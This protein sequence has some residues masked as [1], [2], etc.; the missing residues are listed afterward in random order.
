MY[1]E[2]SRINELKP[3]PMQMLSTPTLKYYDHFMMK[4]VP[5]F[6]FEQNEGSKEVLSLKK[7]VNSQIRNLTKINLLNFGMSIAEKSVFLVKV[8]NDYISSINLIQ[9][10]LA[11]MKAQ[12]RSSK[13]TDEDFRKNY[14]ISYKAAIRELED[15]IIELDP[16]KQ[17]TQTFIDAVLVVTHSFA[18]AKQVSKLSFDFVRP[19]SFVFYPIRKLVQYSQ[20]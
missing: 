10:K 16:I 18:P 9:T 14:K 13:M 6:I 20:S 4:E 15:L 3:F 2:N 19:L 1:N 12:L 8:L 5:S 11:L 7:E 17:E